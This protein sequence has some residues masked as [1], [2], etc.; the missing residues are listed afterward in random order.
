MLIQVQL[1][2]NEWKDDFD[3]RCFALVL[4]DEN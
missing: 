1:T 2:W 4:L 3:L